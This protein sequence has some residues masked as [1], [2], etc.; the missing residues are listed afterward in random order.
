M[1]VSTAIEWTDATWNVVTGCSKVSEGCRY[2]YAETVDRRFAQKWGHE[3][4]PWTGPNA[5]HNVR[6]HSERL[7]MPLHWRKPRKVFVNSMSDLFHEQVPNEFLDE[8]FGIIL[9]CRLLANRPDHVFQ[10]LTKGLLNESF[11]EI[12]RHLVCML[13][14][15]VL[16]CRQTSRE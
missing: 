12:R 1:S 14:Y 11:C 8:V 5:A 3:F 2:C 10:I 13:L 16:A 15:G 7:T 9:A 6:L 4:K